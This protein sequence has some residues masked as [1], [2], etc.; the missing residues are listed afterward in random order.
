RNKDMISELSIPAPDSK[1]LR[2]PSKYARPLF[3]QC[4]ACLWKQHWSYRW[5]PRY[6]GRP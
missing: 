3:T 6:P 1:E 5:N 4:H 2:F